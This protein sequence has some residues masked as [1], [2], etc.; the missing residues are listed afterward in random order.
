MDVAVIPVVETDRLV[1]R[2]WRE[3]DTEPLSRLLEDPD[4]MRFYPPLQRP[5]R[6]E[7]WRDIATM[8]G[9]WALRGY[10]LWAVD[11]KETGEFVGRIGLYYPEGWPGL[12]VGWFL[13]SHH[14]GKGLA[15]EGGRASLEHAWRQLD[16]DHVVS[17]I[18]RDN[19]ASVRVAEKLGM[20]VEGTFRNIGDLIQVVYGIDRPA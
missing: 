17:V 4:V 2:G 19:L 8:L 20:R 15:T 18:G 16:A 6:D 13:D 11:L 12:E 7:A 5:A 3:D 14:W 1:L 10:G 9:H